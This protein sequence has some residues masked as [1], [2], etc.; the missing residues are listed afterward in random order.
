MRKENLLSV[1]SN[2]STISNGSSIKDRAILLLIIFMAFICFFPAM[3]SYGLLD[4][5]D[6]FFIEAA[7]E[8][9]ECKHYIIT[10]FNYSDW[11]EKPVLAQLL[12]VLAYNIFGVSAWAGRL[13]AALSGFILVIASYL[14]CWRILGRRAAF[15]SAVILCSSPLFVIVGHVAL[16]DEVLSMLFGIAMLYIGVSLSTE[17]KVSLWA[18][19]FCALAILCKGP[20]AIVL[21]GGSLALYLVI[22]CHSWKECWQIF[23]RLRP[24]E[25]AGIVLVLC[26]P[27]FLAAH[28]SSGGAFT[29]QFFLRQNLGRMQGTVNH[30]EAIWYYVPIFLGG[31]FPWCLYLFASFIWLKRLFAFRFQLTQRQKLIVF[32]FSWLVFVGLLFVL[33]P[34]K[35]YTYIVPFSPAVAIV[36]GAYLD[37][38]ILGNRIKNYGKIGETKTR[39]TI[40]VF[41]P[42]L[43][44]SLACLVTC[45]VLLVSKKLT[46]P[47][48]FIVSCSLLFTA[49]LSLRTC[50]LIWAGKCNRAIVSLSLASIF[51]CA[52]LVPASFCWFYES[53]QTILNK[54]IVAVREQNGNLATLFSPVPSVIFFLQHKVPNIDSLSEL[55]QFCQQGRSPHFLLAKA[56][57]LNIPELQ[58]Q[59]HTVISDGKWYLLSVEGFPWSH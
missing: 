12:Q 51:A 25:G 43:L 1:Q 24:A 34:T 57:C 35:L 10:L 59:R 54:A 13:P 29:E 49:I 40:A 3:Q 38:L 16:T 44:S 18:Y 32:S 26:L 2:S 37:V 19:V 7:R 30:Q 39:E 31:Y 56:N 27:Y 47:L 22:V 50:W 53:H 55:K 21:I 48:L 58:A 14:F 17:G 33:I 23:L 42:P 20:I 36:T 11:Y 46:G 6:S 28:I 45:F 15:L 52:I 9:M 41:F 5:T 4:P 8:M